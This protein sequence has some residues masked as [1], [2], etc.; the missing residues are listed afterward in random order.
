MDQRANPREKETK[1]FIE[2]GLDVTGTEWVRA[3]Y[4]RD[5]IIENVPEQLLSRREWDQ[6]L[7]NPGD[8]GAPVQAFLR[9]IL[10]ASG[11]DDVHGLL[12]TMEN[13]VEENIIAVMAAA[14][15]IGYDRHRLRIISPGESMLHY[16]IHQRKE[17]WSNA[18]VVFDH[19]DDRFV[20]RKMTI[21]GLRLPKQLKVTERDLT[22]LLIRGQLAT[23]QGRRKADEDFYALVQEEFR[24]TIVS[25]VILVG[26]IFELAWMKKS[27]NFL[28][29]RRRVFLGGNMY[30]EGS[31]YAA[32]R[33]FL[34]Q[35]PGDYYFDCEGR[36]KLNIDLAIVHNKKNAVVSL[37][38]AGTYWYKASAEVQILLGREKELKFILTDPVRK[39]TQT[40]F[41]ELNDLPR[42]PE[43]TTR[44][45]VRV[46]CYGDSAY[47]F[48][49]SDMGFGDFFE[50][51]GL[52][53]RRKVI[54]TAEGITEGETGRNTR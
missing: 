37:S 3:C 36:T 11:A 7:E 48:T 39:N 38:K 12:V 21:S 41:L 25:G 34:K 45:N 15:A 13:L 29:E 6:F 35:D 19:R 8:A 9:Q 32:L 42:R 5:G 28:C 54:L 43:K 18:V 2:I 53:V 40:L 24:R 44:V 52:T 49:A 16:M 17:I 4:L 31:C 1:K 47:E 14:G 30:A 33:L 51:S 26:E 46:I 50:P 10:D 20:M 22:G 27:L 23:E